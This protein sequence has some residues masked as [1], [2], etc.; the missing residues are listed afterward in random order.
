MVPHL[1]FREFI[2]IIFVKQIIE[3]ST[4][5]WDHLFEHLALLVSIGFGGQVICVM[6]VYE[7]GLCKSMA[8]MVSPSSSSSSHLSSGSAS[9]STNGVLQHW[10]C[11]NINPPIFQ[12]MIGLCWVNQLW[13]RKICFSPSSIWL[14]LSAQNDPRLWGRSCHIS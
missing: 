10:Q 7:D 6:S 4:P 3:I 14:D 9:G 1:W 11:A 8:R 5:V 13:P 2:E 12:L